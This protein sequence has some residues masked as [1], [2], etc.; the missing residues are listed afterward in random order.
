MYQD[1][2]T[3]VVLRNGRVAIGRHRI[4]S[5]PKFRFRCMR[6][7]RSHAIPPSRSNQGNDRAYARDD[8]PPTV[9]AADDHQATETA[10][11]GAQR[12]HVGTTSVVIHIIHFMMTTSAGTFC[13]CFSEIMPK[14]PHRD[15]GSVGIG[16]LSPP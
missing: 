14:E 5:L 9:R 3:V 1:D 8:D 4:A 16:D 6:T 12:R 15:E 10:R 13:W 7:H 11:G 2:R